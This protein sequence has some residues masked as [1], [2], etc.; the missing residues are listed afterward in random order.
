MILVSSSRPKEKA[1]RRRSAP[2]K[3]EPEEGT[4]LT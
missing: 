4:D 3:E 2:G 1:G